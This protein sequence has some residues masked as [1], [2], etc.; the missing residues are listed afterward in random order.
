MLIGVC[1]GNH[2][3]RI[4]K[5]KD[6]GF[7]YAELNCGAI[8]KSTKE[9]LDA[10]K[11]VGLP[12]LCANCFTGLKV[13]GDERND[14]DLKEYVERMMSKAAYLGI[15]T[16]VYGSS[17]S[18]K[19]PEGWT[20]EK[21]WEQVVS[22]LKDIVAPVAEKYDITVAIEPLRPAECNCI[23]TVKDGIEIA[24]R[25]NHPRI[26]VLADV[27]HMVDQN[28]SIADLATYA[29]YLYHAHISTPYPEGFEQNRIFPKLSHPFDHAVF[30]N[31]IHKAGV[32]TCSIE[33][34]DVEFESD[35]TDAFEVMKC[36]SN[37]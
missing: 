36:F 10:L 1:T 25:V 18:R 6:A 27:F 12:L 17:G 28:E 9:E 14:D 15:K 34:T 2:P 37:L 30:V 24:K 16:T 32:K 22:F 13:V 29:P 35:V 33:A 23:N 4:Q 5:V 11:A 26:R 3:S 31:A 20:K 7:D 8:A 19:I 21:A